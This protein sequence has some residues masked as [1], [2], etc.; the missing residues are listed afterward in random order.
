MK[1]SLP[2]Q[3]HW[4]GAAGTQVEPGDDVL[5]RHDMIPGHRELVI[6]RPGYWVRTEGI[7]EN[8]LFKSWQ[9]AMR[10]RPFYNH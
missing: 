10:Y 4:I 1:F 2:S 5:N 7:V 8:K 6:V 9:F 3:S